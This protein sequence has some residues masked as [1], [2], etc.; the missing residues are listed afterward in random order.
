ML[1]HTM[2]LINEDQIRTLLSP[3]FACHDRPACAHPGRL[4]AAADCNAVHTC[5]SR[6]HSHALVH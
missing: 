6:Q 3:P 1:P 2:W 4:H 5:T